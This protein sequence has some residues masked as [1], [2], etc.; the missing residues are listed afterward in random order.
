MGSC[1]RCGTPTDGYEYCYRCNAFF[2]GIV[3]SDAYIYCVICK[4][5]FNRSHRH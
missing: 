4:G 3:A 1:A 2:K 5:R